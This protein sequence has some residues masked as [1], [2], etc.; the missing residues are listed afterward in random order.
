VIEYN[1][2]GLEN[3][4]TWAEATADRAPT[5]IEEVDEDEPVSPPDDVD[6]AKKGHKKKGKGKKDKKEK[7]KPNF[8]VPDSPSYSAPPGPTYSNQPLSWLGYTQYFA[9]LTKISEKAISSQASTEQEARTWREYMLAKAQLD[10]TKV[11]FEYEVEYETKTDKIYHMKDLTVRSFFKLATR[12]ANDE[13]KKDAII[14]G[15]SN[16]EDDTESTEDN[17][18]EVEDYPLDEMK[19]RKD[20]KKHKNRTWI[21]FL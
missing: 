11:P 10:Y 17:D 9:N 6:G 15:V 8:K 2:S 4:L 12:I 18:M 5:M 19:K 1:I 3:V 13:P 21:T 14:E 20:K 16:S 7:K